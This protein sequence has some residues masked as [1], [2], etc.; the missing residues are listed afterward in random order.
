MIFNFSNNFDTFSLFTK[1]ISNH[2]NTL[3]ITDETREDHIKL[4]SFQNILSKQ[5]FFQGIITSFFTAKSRSCSSFSE[6]AGKS[7]GTP[8]KF[9][10]FRLPNNPP[11]STSQARKLSP[12]RMK[13]FHWRKHGKFVLLRTNFFNQKREKTII[14]KYSIACFNHLNNIFVINKQIVFCAFIRKGRIGGYTNSHTILKIK[15]TVHSLGKIQGK[16]FLFIPIYS[17]TSAKTPVRISGPLVSNAIEIGRNCSGP[18][19]DFSA[20]RTLLILV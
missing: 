13:R 18:P 9:T 2:A 14:D 6:T 19:V 16:T 4:K 7:I 3:C 1:N 20:A 10:P 8:G 11:F 17:L 5:T 15:F 12:E